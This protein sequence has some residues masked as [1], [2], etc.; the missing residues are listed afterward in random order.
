M[1]GRPWAPRSLRHLSRELGDRQHAACPNTVRRLLKKR[2][3]S[4]KANRKRISGK[5]HRDR[6]IQFQYIERQRQKFAQA[7]WPRISV[8]AKKKELVGNFKSAGQAWARQAEEVNIYDFPPDAL[9]RATPYGVYDI[10]RNR[11]MVS[12]GTSADTAEFAVDSVEAWWQ[13]QG[14]PAYPNAQRLL[15][16]ADGGGSNGH[17]CRLWKRQLQEWSDRHRVEVTVCH[18]PTGASKWN[19]VEHRLF[20]YISIN[21]AAKPLRTLE[22]LL[23][24]LRGTRT[25]GG[26][27]VEARLA[28]KTYHAKVKV[29]DRDM[30]A[31]KLRRH[32]TCPNW[33]YTLMPR[34]LG[35]AP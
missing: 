9:C 12:V 2:G 14:A 30:K 21:W 16:L 3:F 24:C 5:T 6:E 1:G 20:S 18:Y 27:Q 13:H 26:L 31:L 4:L 7:G 15:I 22:T 34:P 35:P 25:K 32:D 10:G 17:R 19:P 29:P 33:N 23:A 28:D 11:G 8:D